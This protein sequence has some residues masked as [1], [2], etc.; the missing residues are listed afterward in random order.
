MFTH[1]TIGPEGNQF[2]PDNQPTPAVKPVVYLIDDDPDQLEFSKGLI[3]A[4]HFQVVTFQSGLQFLEQH[5]HDTPGCAVL[6]VVMPEI[7]GIELQKRLVSQQYVRPHILLSGHADVPMAV[8]AMS[9]GASGFLTKPYRVPELLKLVQDAVER[10]LELRRQSELWR[11]IEENLQSLTE[12]EHQV[13]DLILEGEPNKRIARILN[14]SHR[15]V[16][17]HRSHV[18][19]KLG[20]RSLASLIRTVLLHPTRGATIRGTSNSLL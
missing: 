19:K 14:I 8:E 16:E 3:E 9:R 15:T 13:L 11:S 1:P 12:R 5:D 18:M 10:D 4:L 7:N 6:D 17:L 20:A 2:L